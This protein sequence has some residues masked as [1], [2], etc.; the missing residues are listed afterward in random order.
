MAQYY[1]LASA[2]HYPRHALVSL[3]A[4]SLFILGDIFEVGASLARV[5]CRYHRRSLIAAGTWALSHRDAAAAVGFI[6]MIG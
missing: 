3:C 6:E 5:D 1:L 2:A 4:P